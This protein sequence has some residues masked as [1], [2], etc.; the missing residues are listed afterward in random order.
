M[1]FNSLDDFK[2]AIR[3][4]YVMNGKEIKFVKNDLLRLRV[5]ARLIAV[6]LLHL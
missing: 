3:E 2:D 1:E 6:I 4:W 5:F